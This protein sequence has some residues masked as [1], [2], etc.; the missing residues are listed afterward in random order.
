LRNQLRPDG[1]PGN[2]PVFFRKVLVIPEAVIKEVHLPFDTE[3]GGCPTF[4]LSDGFADSAFTGKGQKRVAVIWHQQENMRI[5]M[6][7]IVPEFHGIQEMIGSRVDRELVHRAIPA[8]NCNKPDGPGGINPGR[9]FVGQGATS[10]KHQQSKWIFNFPGEL[11][12]NGF[13]N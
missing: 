2:V 10:G 1:I 9:G 8:A 6:I 4:P 12:I 11:K 7:V 13:R 5:P 3:L